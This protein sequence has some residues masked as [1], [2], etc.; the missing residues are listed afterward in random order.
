MFLL[1]T[2]AG[3]EDLRVKN[4]I[5]YSPP[6]PTLSTNAPPTPTTPVSFVSGKGATET[7]DG[8]LPGG[9]ASQIA[10]ADMLNVWTAS[11]LANKGGS[12]NTADGKTQSPYSSFLCHSTD[13]KLGRIRI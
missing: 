10:T 9:L 2:Q 4:E 11:K 3:A 5:D 12:V 8:G 1:C 6:P 7:I 13:F